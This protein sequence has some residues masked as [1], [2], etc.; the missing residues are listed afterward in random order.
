VSPDEAQ[1]GI[2]IVRYGDGTVKKIMR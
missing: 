2:F 1:H